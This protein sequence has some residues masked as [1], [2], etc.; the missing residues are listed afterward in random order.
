MT[1]YWKLLAFYITLHTWLYLIL[2]SSYYLFR[3]LK[4][5]QPPLLGLGLH[6]MIILL[7]VIETWLAPITEVRERECF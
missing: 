3:A 5:C 4:L 6:A 1:I 7:S 2:S